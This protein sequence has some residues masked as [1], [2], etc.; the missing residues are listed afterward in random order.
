MGKRGGKLF[1]LTTPEN[2]KKNVAKDHAEIA[3]QLKA[4][5]EAK[6]KEINEHA[7][8]IGELKKAR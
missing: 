4:L 6:W 3:E 5:A 2:E 8:P 1:D 7:R